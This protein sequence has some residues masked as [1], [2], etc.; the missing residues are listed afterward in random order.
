MSD[1]EVKKTDK[2]PFLHRAYILSGDT[3]TSLKE[4]N[5]MYYVIGA[6]EKNK[7]VT[8]LKKSDLRRFSEK[9]TSK[10]RPGHLR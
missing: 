2:N 6:L 7:A 3:R 10:Q 9:V 4:R 1:I 8:I 5:L